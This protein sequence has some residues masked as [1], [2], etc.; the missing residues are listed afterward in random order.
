M[1][2]NIERFS[3]RVENYIKYRPGYPKE[4][5][6]YLYINTGFS[7]E[8]IIADIGSGTGILTRLLLDRGSHVIG[9]EPNKEMRNA[10]EKLLE[11]YPKFISVE[12]TAEATGLSDKSVDHIICAQAFHWFNRDACKKEFERILK[13][14]GKVVLV[15]NK[16]IVKEDGFSAGYE[17]LL[18]TYANDYNEVNHKLITEEELK[19][20]FKDR[21]LSKA[22]FENVQLFDFEG[23]KGR[24]LSNSY[25]PM[26]G[27][28]N[29]DIL[30]KE[31]RK[32]FDTY[33]VEGK[34]AFKYKTESYTG[35]V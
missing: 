12:G 32:L 16:R 3:D 19:T 21:V 11:E 30:M 15:W 17:I 23:L 2:K 8:S 33:S 22:V 20:F 5:I 14:G 18:R 1:K 13:A 34:V 27:E 31:L 25:A 26:P 29:Y 28:T 9:V 10:A 35:E 6:D 24:L 7:T 4:F